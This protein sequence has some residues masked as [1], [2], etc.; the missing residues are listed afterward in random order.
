MTT[1][2]SLPARP[3][4]ESLRKE[5]KKLSRQLAA[6]HAE[7]IARVRSQLPDVHTPLAR[8]EAQLVIA[9]EY[10]YAGW[11]DL[12]AAVRERS[13]RDLQWAVRQAKRIIHDNDV[14]ALQGLLAEYPAL[15]SWGA[16]EGG[17]LGVA[18]NSYGD[19][20]D[21]QRERQFTRREC[22]E[23]LIVAGAVVA[24]S[25]CEGLLQSRARGLLQLYQSKGLLPPSLKYIVGLGDFEQVRAYFRDTH[26][27]TAGSMLAALNEAFMVACRFQYEAIASFLLE[28]YLTLDPSLRDRIDNGPGRAALLEY[29]LEEWPLSYIDAAP[30]DPWQ[31]FVMHRV[32]R[33]I[34][35]GELATFAD[36]LERNAWLLEDRWVAFQVGMIERATLQDRPVLMLKFL[37]L[38]PALLRRQPPPPSRAIEFALVYG[39]PH[40]V[41]ILTR[42]W[43]FPDDLPYAAGSGDFE[44]V[45]RWFEG[46]PGTLPAQ[47]V[48]NTAF[49]WAVLNRQ[50]EIADFLLQRGADINT[51]WGSHEPASVLHEL[52]LREDYEGMQFLIDRGIDMTIAD[53]RWGATAEG[54]A[55]RAVQNPRLGDWLAAAAARRTGEL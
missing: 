9:R 54:W 50:L 3:S 5:A 53:H 46:T 7:A 27:N 52:V 31:L 51:R 16:D 33:A 19:S 49:A 1:T 22:A 28:R 48:L 8:R 21:P 34:H 36:L 26:N 4:L 17:L 12:T 43:L 23:L 41:P 6:G 35:A 20:Y 55:R 47:A 44:R 32:V 15:L 18:S 40:L 25:V 30:T 29:L 10:G 24:P 42:V 11:E 13:G 2:K 37:E 39:K 38:A 14:A 45:R